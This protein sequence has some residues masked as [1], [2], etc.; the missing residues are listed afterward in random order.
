MLIISLHTENL[1]VRK[2]GCLGPYPP[3]SVSAECASDNWGGGGGLKQGNI[4]ILNPH[5]WK[6]Y[7]SAAEAIT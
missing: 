2:K 7:T 4:Q 6:Q 1:H 5:A 3:R